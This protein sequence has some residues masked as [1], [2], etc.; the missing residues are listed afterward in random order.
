M[1]L[2]LRGVCPLLAVFDMAASLRFYRDILGF[3]IVGAAPTHPAGHPDNYGW[4]WLRHGASEIMLNSLHDPA[5]PK[6]ARPD[7]NRVAAHVD[8][9]LYLGAP[10]VDGVYRYLRENGIDSELPANAPYGMRQLYV[11]DPDGFVLCFQWPVPASAT[12][13]GALAAAT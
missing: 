13:D 3:Q 11:K 4:V 1:A 10:D 9:S 6:P 7:P 5:D 8:T 2:D 12:T